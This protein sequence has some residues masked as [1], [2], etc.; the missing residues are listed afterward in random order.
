VRT[1]LSIELA[2]LLTC[3]IAVIPYEDFLIARNTLLRT[4]PLPNDVLRVL[5]NETYN[6]TE[7][8]Y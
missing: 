5:S 6:F 3:L 8:I 4:L 7:K 1:S 2:H